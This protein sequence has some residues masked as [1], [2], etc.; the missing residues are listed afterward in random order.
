VR[1]ASYAR[2]GRRPS[3]P[4]R[5]TPAA[6]LP[7]A[8]ESAYAPPPTPAPTPASFLPRATEPLYAPPAPSVAETA[9]VGSAAPTTGTR[10]HAEAHIAA[11]HVNIGNTHQ[12][13]IDV[14]RGQLG[15]LSVGGVWTD[16]NPPHFAG[17]YGKML[18]DLDAGVYLRD[19][20]AN[21]NQAA[22]HVRNTAQANLNTWAITD[23]HEEPDYDENG[24]PTTM[25]HIHFKTNTGHESHVTLPDSQ[26]TPAHVAKAVEEK[27][28]RIVTV[29][30]MHSGN[31]P[32]SE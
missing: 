26:F 9:N 32:V 15:T 25:H 24:K 8:T 2:S 14:L 17:A 11:A 7:R 30:R 16:V 6:F 27:A 23:Q 31:A 5:P 12:Q 29:A 3:P 4:R 18:Q 1:L 22:A 21:L 10:A 20:F 13:E 28:N 19:A